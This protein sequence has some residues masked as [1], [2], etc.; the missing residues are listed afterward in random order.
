MKWHLFSV[1]CMHLK[2]LKSGD[3]I[4]V[5]VF[6]PPS[7][8]GNVRSPQRLIKRE[9]TSLN[10][11]IAQFWSELS[12]KD[13]SGDLKLWSGSPHKILLSNNLR[14]STP[15]PIITVHPFIGNCLTVTCK[16]YSN[17]PSKGSLLFAWWSYSVQLNW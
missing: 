7:I 17:Y 10:N 1:Q 14:S 11:C 2:P 16:R 3:W 15:S 4:T 12:Q 8:Y 13:L 6:N 9:G 5:I